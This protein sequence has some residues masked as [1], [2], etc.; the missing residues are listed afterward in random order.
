M[1]YKQHNNKYKDVIYENCY[2]RLYDERFTSS[3]DAFYSETQIKLIEF[4]EKY[5]FKVFYITC[6]PKTKFQIKFVKP[7]E[8][9]VDN[10]EVQTIKNLL[11][12]DI[13]YLYE[14]QLFEV[15]YT[16]PKLNNKNNYYFDIIL[17]ANN[18]FD[19]S[20]VYNYNFNLININSINTVGINNLSFEFIENTFNKKANF[21]NWAPFLDKDFYKWEKMSYDF[22]LKNYCDNN[23]DNYDFRKHFNISSYFNEKNFNQNLY[24]KSCFKLLDMGIWTLDREHIIELNE[25]GSCVSYIHKYNMNPTFI[26]NFAELVGGCISVKANNIQN[27]FELK[28]ESCTYCSL[29]DNFSDQN[30]ILGEFDKKVIKTGFIDIENLEKIHEKDI[31]EGQLK[32]K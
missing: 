28:S 3:F 2:R 18:F 15:L 10:I 7:H 13:Y 1:N 11:S 25:F 19:L 6:T 29:L 30:I 23:Y 14:N 17:V 12:D 16:I 5:N 20:K 31:W 9:D 4:I 21:N 22:Y 32:K 26:T 24:A 8:V 27:E